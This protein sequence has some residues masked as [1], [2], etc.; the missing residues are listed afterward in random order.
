M[1]PIDQQ[2][3]LAADANPAQNNIAWYGPGPGSSAPLDVVQQ[4]YN[5]ALQFHQQEFAPASHDAIS[6]LSTTTKI[7]DV[8]DILA[9]TQEAYLSKKRGRRKITSAAISWWKALSTRM[10]QYGS[11]INTVVSSNPEYAALVWGAMKFL[12]TVTINH[13]ELSSKIARAF[14]EI[15]D[16][17]PEVEFVS[18]KLYPTERIQLTLSN[19]YAQVVEFCI[20]ATKWYNKTRQSPIKKV[21]SAIVK[22]W[23]LEFH[24][25]K[26][27]IDSQFRRLR[28]QSAIAHQAETRDIHVKLG[29]IQQILSHGCSVS[30]A[31]GS[32]GTPLQDNP[33]LTRSLPFIFERVSTYLACNT[34]DPKQALAMGVVMR[35][36]RRARGATIPPAAWESQQLRDWISMPGS[37]VLQLQGCSLRTE[38]SRDVAI[39]LVQLLQTMGLHV[40]WYLTSDTSTDKPTHPTTTPID[41]IRSL[42]KQILDQ[43]GD[44]AKSWGINDSH[45][46]DC[47]TKRDWLRL[48]VTVLSHVPKLVLVIDAQRATSGMADT[49]AEFW[50][51]MKEQNIPTTVKILVLINE[52]P[53]SALGGFPVLPATTAP[54]FGLPARPRS[55]PPRSRVLSRF[56][57]SRGRVPRA[58]LGEGLENFK[59]FVLRLL[60]S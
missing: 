54:R 38:Q 55:S 37:K 29:E 6:W 33:S 8:L 59:P 15:G 13:E 1:N 31:F 32:D 5:R 27:S 28:E 57:I 60:N 46:A 52:S 44:T 49:I 58:Q 47:Q 25:V 35:D 24:D 18:K 43:H 48:L 22:P 7:N 30:Q 16:V 12:F 34:L 21:F 14:A 40:S 39:D 41:I 23:P 56:G 2:L 26:M 20:R 11:V 36:R 53:A 3:V 10:M 51:E 42:I 50:Q 4:A 17:L 9:K 45:F 19:V